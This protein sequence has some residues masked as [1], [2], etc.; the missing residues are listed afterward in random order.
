MVRNNA[1]V[2][3][4][5]QILAKVAP[6]GGG[7]ASRGDWGETVFVIRCQCSHCVVGTVL[8]KKGSG[9]SP[10]GPPEP[11]LNDLYKKEGLQP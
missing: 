6:Q 5:S 9:R 3:L 11:V 7:C 8:G 4:I 2:E 10:S 1:W